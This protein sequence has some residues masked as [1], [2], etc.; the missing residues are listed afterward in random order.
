MQKRV[1]IYD[2]VARGP[3]GD[4][5]G[6]ACADCATWFEK[7]NGC[8]GWRVKRWLLCFALLFLMG[9]GFLVPFA[10]YAVRF[11]EASSCRLTYTDDAVISE[12]EMQS[13][14]ADES[15]FLS[16][17]S[18]D[19]KRRTCVCKGFEDKD[20]KS[21]LPTDEVL[22]WIAPGDL[23]SLSD[24]GA[25]TPALPAT[26]LD[27]YR[28]AY[29]QKDHV[30][31]CLQQ[32]LLLD[33]WNYDPSRI[34]VADGGRHC[35]VSSSDGSSNV[36]Q[37][38]LGWDGA[39]YCLT[40]AEKQKKNDCAAK[41]NIDTTKSNRCMPSIYS[42]PIDSQLPV[43]PYCSSTVPLGMTT[44]WCEY[45]GGTVITLASTTGSTCGLGGSGGGG[46]RRVTD[47]LCQP[48]TCE[49]GLSP[50]C[51]SFSG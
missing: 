37:F 32:R 11:G 48:N 28:G 44:S 49:I 27:K 33:L 46:R 38:F 42:A 16:V 40:T 15:W 8:C 9:V 25:I 30:K 5:C 7:T 22:V 2:T 45:C 17:P 34:N 19:W 13:W 51:T 10:I 26:F 6:D 3:Q 29:G 35:H 18:Y 47:S 23:A 20:P 4:A 39:L 31:V 24:E 12:S 43:L 36:E 50:C 1:D 21:L 14:M 41:V